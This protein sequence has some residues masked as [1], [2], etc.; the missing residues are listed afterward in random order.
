MLVAALLCAPGLGFGYFYDDF[1]FLTKSQANPLAY[2]L[3]DPAESFYRPIPQGLYFLSLLSIGPA[4]ER[5]GHWINLA[6]VAASIVLLVSLTSR[7]AGQRA[8]FVAGLVFA[9]SAS[10]PGLV[11]WI[12]AAQDLL[13]IVFVLAALCLR[14]AGRSGAAA[15]CAAC[16]ILSKETALVVFPVLVAWDRLVGRPAARVGAQAALYA[17]IALLWAAIHPGIRSLA[18]HGFQ[19]GATGYL[20]LEHPDRWIPYLRSYVLALLNVPLSGLSTPWP[21]RLTAWGAAALAVLW[22]SLRASSRAPVPDEAGT[23]IRPAR[24]WALSA[25]L[26][27]PPILLPAVLVRPWASYFVCMAA[28]GLALLAG[29]LLSARPARHASLLLSAFLAVGLWSRGANLPDDGLTLTEQTF[30]DAARA[31]RRVESDFKKLEP[32]L[33]RGAHVL[34][35]VAGTKKL[36]IHQMLQDGDALR[37]WYRDPTLVTLPPEQRRGGAAAELL[38][39]VT[40]QLDVVRIDPN[41]SYFRSSGTGYPQ[42]DEVARP[43]R[44]YA[45]GSAAI[46][47]TGRAVFILR[48]MAEA[49]ERRDRS[50]DLR[51]AAMA[52][53]DAGRETEAESLKASAPPLDPSEAR[54]MVGK[55]LAEPTGRPSLDSLAFWAYGVSPSDPEA[56]RYLIGQYR[57]GGYRRSALEIARRLRDLR[58]GDPEAAALVREFEPKRRPPAPRASAVPRRGSRPPARRSRSGCACRP[59]RGPLRRPERPEARRRRGDAIGIPAPRP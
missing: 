44:S 53:R 43:I 40:E 13:A 49:D 26:A 10:V 14:D 15:A 17:G 47:E 32:S 48:R 12:S 16:A 33:P 57:I 28:I 58:P 30:V 24:A 8:G 36:G 19:S 20:G 4:G 39:R 23:A 29:R 35:S 21:E 11:L 31:I 6:L 9:A 37:L 2:L 7:L 55:V 22:F 1:F 56:L 45:R 27:V 38:I 46:G 54:D 5:A 18:L 34:L 52:L 42:W 51:L 41:T 25:L 3:P 50:Y 59:S